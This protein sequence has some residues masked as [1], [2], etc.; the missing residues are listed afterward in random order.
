[1]ADLTLSPDSRT[2]LDGI[3]QQMQKN[4]ESD[5]YIQNV[6]NDFKQKYGASSQPS[7]NFITN[8]LN[9]T[10]E[11]MSIGNILGAISDADT[12]AGQG[13]WGEALGHLARLIPGGSMQA[14]ATADPKEI[15]AAI[16]QAKQHPASASD[17]ASTLIPQ[18][19]AVAGSGAPES[20]AAT[21]ADVADAAIASKYGARIAEN[22]PAAAKAVGQAA[23][24]VATVGAAT[25]ATVLSHGL[26]AGVLFNAAA[27]VIKGGSLTNAAKAVS[28]ILTKPTTKE[29]IDANAQRTPVWANQ[30]VTEPPPGETVTPVDKPGFNADG[31]Y[32]LPSGRVIRQTR[33]VST[34]ISTTPEVSPK[35][36]VRSATEADNTTP[37]TLSADT[38]QKL[39][40]A[41]RNG[42]ANGMTPAQKS[43]LVTAVKNGDSAAV[44][45]ILVNH[46]ATRQMQADVTNKVAVL[47][48]YMKDHNIDPE[49]V[50]PKDYQAIADQAVSHAKNIDTL[51]GPR[52]GKYRGISPDT[53]NLIKQ[54]LRQ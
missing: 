2:K 19:F 7:G 25:G 46:A 53:M 36:S 32:T 27:K 44:N 38:Q 52:S 50:D 31:T 1:M 30:P 9:K 26:S 24:D 11:K 48:R 18:A 23:K 15:K 10:G 16:D 34:N 33:P 4:G 17:I 37:A 40:E 51:V 35:I 21:G 45:D 54:S 28:D 6:V 29:V 8:T 41:A 22:T 14:P 12:A 43:Q 42:T 47:A 13:K 3:V 5:S 49:Q 20:A 39:G